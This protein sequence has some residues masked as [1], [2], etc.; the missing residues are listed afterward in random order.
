MNLTSGTKLGPYKIVALLGA[1]AVWV[2]CIAPRDARL[3]RDVAVK[4]LPQAL[5]LDADRLR[6]HEQGAL[7]TA[8]LKHPN[9]LAEFDTGTREGAPESC[10]SYWRAKGCEKDYCSG[11]M[12]CA[13]L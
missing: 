7:A 10:S 11:A 13:R 9:I 1:R 5:S 2:N 6:R 12:P 4:I 3:Q 8:A